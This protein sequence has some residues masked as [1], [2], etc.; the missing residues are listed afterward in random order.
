MKLQG[1]STCARFALVA[2]AASSL[3]ALADPF[4]VKIHPGEHWWGVCNSF[5]TNMPF[6]TET[7]G[8]KADLF[9]WNYG[10]QPASMLLSD[11]GRIVH[12]PEQT[13]VSIDGGEIRMESHGADVTLEQGGDCLRTAYRLASTKYFPPSGKM[14]DPL[15]FSAP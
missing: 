15:F 10:G 11:K 8:F 14:P 7:R 4:V 13:R 12:C 1:S 3:M 5:G 6:T 9:A 2:L